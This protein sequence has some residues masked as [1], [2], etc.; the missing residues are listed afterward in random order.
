MTY[1]AVVLGSENYHAIGICRDLLERRLPSVELIGAYGQNETE[2]ERLRKM[3]VPCVT[4]DPFAFVESA[5]IVFVTTRHGDTHLPLCLPYMKKGRLIWVDKPLAISPEHYER[6]HSEAQK[7]GTLLWGSSFMQTA[8]SIKAV[9]SNIDNANRPILGATVM[10]PVR[11]EEENGG[12]FFYTQHLVE[13]VLYLFGREIEGVYCS[14]NHNGYSVLFRYPTFDAVGLYHKNSF[15]YDISVS[16]PESTYT[17]HVT[18]EDVSTLHAHV[19]QQVDKALKTGQLPLTKAD[20]DAPFYLLHA[21]YE[22]MKTGRFSVF[23]VAN[24]Q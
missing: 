4:G 2:N 21:L 13:I 24:A 14:E 20:M 23:A 15:H 11:T 1:K 16:V 10:C 5:D 8:D 9:K 3:G 12:F 6:L 19:L 22:S 18:P 17:A 7:S